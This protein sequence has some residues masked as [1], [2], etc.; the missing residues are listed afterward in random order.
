M[1]KLPF[2]KADIEVIAASCERV[3]DDALLQRFYA[4]AINDADA[5]HAR[6]VTDY[7]RLVTAHQSAQAA[8][9][10]LSPVQR[11]KVAPPS[12]PVRPEPPIQETPEQ[13]CAAL[14]SSMRK[15]L[16]D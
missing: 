10:R 13:A 7:E 16:P 15:A 12:R 2:S 5:R 8:W 3:P 11:E 9:A 1:T 4:S 6:Q 14:I